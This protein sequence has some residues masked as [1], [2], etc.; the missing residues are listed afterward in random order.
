MRH[1]S[2]RTEQTYLGVI[3]RYVAYHGNRSPANMGVPE[4]RAFLSHLAT[5]GN[6]AA[7]TQNV[8]FSALLFLFNTHVLNRPGLN[9]RSLLDA[10]TA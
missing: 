2:Y 3:R 8:A 9:V 7:S 5:Q 6:V 1:L 4:I 10:V